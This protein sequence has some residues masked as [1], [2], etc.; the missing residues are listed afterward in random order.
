MAVFQGTHQCSKALVSVPRLGMAAC[1]HVDMGHL[2]EH[3][4]YKQRSQSIG[5]KLQRLS[6]Q[7]RLV[8]QASGSAMLLPLGA[9]LSSRATLQMCSW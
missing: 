6:M 4:G 7:L 8:L 1:L 2:A 5:I 9:R 3:A